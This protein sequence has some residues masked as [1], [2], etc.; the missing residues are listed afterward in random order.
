MQLRRAGGVRADP[1][2]DT[3]DGLRHAHEWRHHAEPS[4][5]GPAGLGPPRFGRGIAHLTLF[6]APLGLFLVVLPRVYGFSSLGRP[7]DLFLFAVPFILA[8]SLMG[9]S[10]GAWFRRRETAVVLFV[11][12]TLPQFFLV[13]VSWPAE[14]IPPALRAAGRVFPSEAAIDG[15]VRVNQMGPASARFGPTGWSCGRS[16]APTSSF[17]FCPRASARAESQPMRLS[18]GRRRALVTGL[19]FAVIAGIAYV[20]A[21]PVALPPVTGVVRSTEIL[22]APELSGR[23]GRLHAKA[24]DQVSAGD[25]LAELDNPELVAA[26]AEAK[27]ALDVADATRDRIYAGIRQEQVDILAHEIDKRRA[28]LVRAQQEYR[29]IAALAANYNAPRQRLDEVSAAAAS[30]QAELEVAIARHAEAQAGPTPRS[31]P[32]RTLL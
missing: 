21:R 9:Q 5:P 22:I 30:A 2:A 1:A 6:L 19:V 10:A 20:S 31:A 11:A 15:L 27:A 26:V 3:A 12:T 18:P 29:R 24:D 23:L 4:F 13:G 17:P 32:S 16:P 28:N 14:S 8:T 25:V 7:L